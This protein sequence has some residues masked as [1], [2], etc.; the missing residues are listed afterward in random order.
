M[1]TTRGCPYDCSWCA[2]PLYGRRYAQRKPS[3]VADEMERLVTEINPDHVWFADDIFGLSPRWIEDFSNAL[4]ERRVRVPFTVQSRPDLMTDTAC[5][6]LAR[7]GCEEIW[8]GVESGAQSV[9]DAMNKGTTIATVRSVTRLLDRWGVR[10]S[11]FLQ[12]GYPGEDWPEILASRDLVR[13]GAPYDIGVSVSY[14]LPGTTFHARVAD[15]LS[16]KTNWAH[17]DDLA[18]L[19]QGAFSTKFYRQV[20]DLL[21][22]EAVV[23]RLEEDSDRVQQLDRLNQSWQSLGRELDSHRSALPTTVRRAPER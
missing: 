7:A 3:A 13:D 18:M 21:H 22:E 6:A 4:V 15:E 17:S 14:P 5:Q 16:E 11:W 20:R 8:L 1:V 23:S 10:P 19:F 12:L 9:L 2:K